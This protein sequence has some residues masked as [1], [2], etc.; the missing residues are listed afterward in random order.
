[1]T[2]TNTDDSSD[3]KEFV[4]VKVPRAD[5][6]AAKRIRPDGSD[7]THGDCL[8]AGAKALA[9]RLD[10]IDGIVDGIDSETRALM[11]EILQDVHQVAEERASDE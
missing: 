4:T 6:K 8:V 1:M 11:L 10:Q 7:I 3:A 2:N 9:D 5:R